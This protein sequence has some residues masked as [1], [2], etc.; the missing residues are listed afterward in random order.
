M[1]SQT[2]TE[3]ISA[4]YLKAGLAISE[5]EA[6]KKQRVSGYDERLRKL[7]ALTDVLLIKQLDEQ[8]EM[9]DT[10]E[11]LNPDLQKLLDSPLHGLD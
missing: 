1:K 5:I 10:K 4:Q 11:I 6:A 2:K 8:V 7:N 9:F 3:W